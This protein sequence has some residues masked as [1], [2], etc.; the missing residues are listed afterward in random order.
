MRYL[1]FILI[2]FSILLSNSEDILYLKN[3]SIIKGEIIEQV[4]N[5]Y[6]KI[7][8]GNNILVYRY[9]ELDKITFSNKNKLDQNNNQSNNQYFNSKKNSIGFSNLSL[10]F[11]K[12]YNEI[13]DVGLLYSY[14]PQQGIYPGKLYRYFP[15]IKYKYKKIDDIS[16]SLTTGFLHQERHWTNWAGVYGKFTHL[17]VSFI[18]DFSFKI[19]EKF[20]L[21]LGTK[22]FKN[23]NFN[24]YGITEDYYQ[25]NPFGLINFHF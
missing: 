5:D 4:F 13:L 25:I 23:F 21:S 20:S 14:I 11:N 9:N 18:C 24:T 17:S 19:S 8:S 12:F 15:Y 22:I 6:V 16:I 2:N 10:N 3:G 7:K 1:T